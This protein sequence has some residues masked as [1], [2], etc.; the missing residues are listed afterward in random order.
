MKD[1]EEY[2][3]TTAEDLKIPAT[4]HDWNEG[5][6]TKAPTC[7]EK[8]IMTYTCKRCD[9]TYTKDIAARGH[10]EGEWKITKQ[11]TA[12]AKGEKVKKCTRCGIVLKREI[13]P[14]KGVPKKVSGILLSTVVASGN[15]SL[16]F[17]WSGLKGADGYDV[18]L[19]RSSGNK[20]CALVKTLNGKT[21][22]WTATGLKKKTS[23]KGYVKGFIMVDGS[24]KY[25]RTSPTVFAYT[26]GG[27]KKYTNAKSVKVKKTKVSIKV[28]K[29]FK[30]KASVIKVKK[31]KKLMGKGYG[32]KLRYIST[33]T[34]IATVNGSGK[35]IGKSKGKCTVY[36]YAINGARKAVAVTVK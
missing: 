19:G 12:T 27:D 24:K 17:T 16:T 31:S 4:G 5:E 6:I 10:V 32:P 22:K 36:V 2:V 18:F 23:Y 29:S 26:S 14:A 30:I 13:I 20:S 15:N 28:G 33:N 3:E 25:V 35:I 8:G 11:P 21:F 1:G 7:T 9:E 34:K